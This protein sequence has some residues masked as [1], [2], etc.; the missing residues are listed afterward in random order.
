MTRKEA[1]RLTRLI[2]AGT[3]LCTGAFFNPTVGLADVYVTPDIISED[4][5]YRTEAI[6]QDDYIFNRLLKAQHEAQ[7]DGNTLLFWVAYPSSSSELYRYMGDMISQNKLEENNICRLVFVGDNTSDMRTEYIIDNENMVVENFVFKGDG[8]YAGSNTDVMIHGFRAVQVEG[9]LY[10]GDR[11]SLYIGFDGSDSYFSG[12]VGDN[13]PGRVTISL[14]N[15]GTWYVPENVDVVDGDKL[16]VSSHDG[17]IIDLWHTS[18][19]SHRSTYGGK[20][21]SM[22]N[23]DTIGTGYSPTTFVISVDAA[24]SLVDTIAISTQWNDNNSYTLKIIDNIDRNSAEAKEYQIE[25]PVLTQE[26][27]YV[28]TNAPETVE[29]YTATVDSGLSKRTMQLTTTLETVTD[30]RGMTTTLKSMKVADITD[31]GDSNNSSDNSDNND[32]KDGSNGSDGSGGGSNNSANSNSGAITGTLTDSTAGPAAKLAATSAMAAQGSMSAWRSENNDLHKRMGD[33]RKS[34]SAIGAWG[35][36]YGGETDIKTSAPS[37]VKLHGIQ[38]GYDR[39]VDVKG[40]K[41][42]KG[43]A[44]SHSKGDISANDGTGDTHS[45]MV[46]VYGSFVKPNG[47]YTDAIVKY[48]NI[49][50]AMATY[51]GG[52]YYKTDSS[53][54]GINLSIEQGYR[55][56]LGGGSYIEPQAEINYGHISSSSYTMQM[57][58]GDGAFVQNDAVNSLIGRIG[59]NVGKE[60]DKG[61]IYAKVSLLHEFDGDVGVRAAYGSTTRYSK[62]SMKDTWCEYGIGFNSEIGAANH[63]YGE[64]TKTAGADKISDKWKFNIGYRHEF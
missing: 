55:K 44:A 7:G 60:T 26:N 38:A 14:G 27:E 17:G 25:K 41:L 30:S 29:T 9:N 47:S 57:N 59:V 35:R 51:S 2:F 23:N 20:K 37:T 1:M 52:D 10:A 63:L 53:A 42:F 5:I 50:N 62:E 22:V 16:D 58:N 3:M 13:S 12:N 39:K 31:A 28:L 36:Y 54:N 49:G 15:G 34:D 56:E 61:S 24:N 11:G 18:P 33:L 46:G 45:T 6:T 32:N 40:G 64:V 4:M 8:I 21:F 48:G 19:T 43:I